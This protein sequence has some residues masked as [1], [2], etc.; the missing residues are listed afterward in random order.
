L[1]PKEGDP[2]GVEPQ[3]SGPPPADLVEGEQLFWK[4]ADVKGLFTRRVVTGYLITNYRCF[5]WDAETD[6]VRAS[7]PLSRCETVV[8]FMR[9]G[10]RSAR[11][12]RFMQPP[13]D[14]PASGVEDR[15]TTIGDVSFRVDDKT[16]MV[17]REVAEPEKVKELV[18]TLR[19]RGGFPA[20]ERLNTV[21][22]AGQR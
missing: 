16:I 10:A 8:S 4:M 15:L 11:G 3:K 12:G 19:V 21:V 2:M 22:S 6:A 17:F 5:V 13:T 9:K 20:D 7:V 18:D 14:E 1:N